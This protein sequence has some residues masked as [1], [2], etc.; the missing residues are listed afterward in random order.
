MGW[1]S[2]TYW[3]FIIWESLSLNYEDV[4]VYNKWL[5]A[6]CHQ[7]LRVLR[8]KIGLRL[9]TNQDTGSQILGLWSV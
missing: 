3:T 1:A 9:S 4:E 7:R 2:I 6:E 5:S 8:L